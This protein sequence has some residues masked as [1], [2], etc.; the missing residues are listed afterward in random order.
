MFLFERKKP[1][2]NKNCVLDMMQFRKANKLNLRKHADKNGDTDKGIEVAKIRESELNQGK[3]AGQCAPNQESTTEANR[4]RTNSDETE[5]ASAL[6]AVPLSTEEISHCATNEWLSLGIPILDAQSRD[7]AEETW[8]EAKLRGEMPFLTHKQDRLKS[9]STRNLFSFR[10]A[11]AESSPSASADLVEFSADQ[12]TFAGPT[13]PAKQW[14]SAVKF[15]DSKR[16]STLDFQIAIASV[17]IFIAAI[18]YG[19]YYLCNQPSAQRIF[20][21]SRVQAES[22]ELV[23]QLDDR[24]RFRQPDSNR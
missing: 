24:W 15:H 10:S 13:T 16:Q 2:C 1:N 20:S 9:L 21:I 18:L 22:L 7:N 6:P 8:L 4:E 14:Q 5:L 11:G 17:L 3:A 12:R 19:T 23:Y